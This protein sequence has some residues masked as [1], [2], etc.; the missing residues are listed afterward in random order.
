VAKYERDVQLIPAGEWVFDRGFGAGHG[1]VR[2]LRVG[3][4]IH[5]LSFGQDGP[6]TERGVPVT[7]DAPP[8]SRPDPTGRWLFNEVQ[9]R[10]GVRLWHVG[11]FSVARP[12]ALERRTCW[13]AAGLAF[14]PGGRWLA[15]STGDWTR[16]TFWPLSRRLPIVIDGY[17]N[18]THPVAISEDSRWVATAWPDGSFRLWPIGDATSDRPRVLAGGKGVTMWNDLAFDP[19]GRF[20]FAV[21][22]VDSASGDARVAAAYVGVLGYM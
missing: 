9:D 13:Y 11:P 8:T 16:L 1:D 3:H 15:A 4:A 12:L 2:L 6:R 20:L 21:G 18:F 19:A 5:V 17:S 14:D 7:G 22:N 10:P